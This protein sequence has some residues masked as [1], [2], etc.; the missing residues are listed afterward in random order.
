[1]GYLMPQFD[2]IPLAG[3]AGCVPVY[4]V[5]ALPAVGLVVSGPPKQD[6]LAVADLAHLGAA[7]A[8]VLGGRVAERHQAGTRPAWRR[9]C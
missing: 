9:A 4:G 7:V 8:A 6:D 5:I 2:G 3:G 1:M